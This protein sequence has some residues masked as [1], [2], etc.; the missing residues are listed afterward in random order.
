VIHEQRAA[1]FL[2]VQATVAKVRD[3]ASSC[4]GNS[5][6]GDETVEA[7]CL[8]CVPSIASSLN[9]PNLVESV[10]SKEGR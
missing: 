9:S 3:F 10:E 8:I 6:V 1:S 7:K 2:S 5:P 4:A